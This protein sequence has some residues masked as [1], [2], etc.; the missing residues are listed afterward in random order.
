M[1][2]ATAELVR[3]MLGVRST[4]VSKRLLLRCPLEHSSADCSRLYDSKPISKLLHLC[5]LSNER[6]EPCVQNSIAVNLASIGHYGP[7]S[8]TWIKESTTNKEM[9]NRYFVSSLN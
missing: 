2:A 4:V 8:I 5:K 1:N 3:S 6:L 7:Q 9:S